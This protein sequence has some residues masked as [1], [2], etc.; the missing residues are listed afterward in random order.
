VAAG[1][2]IITVAFGLLLDVAMDQVVAIETAEP[3]LV[4]KLQAVKDNPV[5]LETILQKKDGPAQITLMW[6]SMLE[7]KAAPD[8]WLQPQAVTAAAAAKAAGYA[9]V[10]A[11]P[12]SPWAGMTISGMSN[13]EPA[14]I[15]AIDRTEGTVAARLRSGGLVAVIVSDAAALTSLRVGGGIWVD[16]SAGKASL[17]GKTACCRITGASALLGR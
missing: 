11:A 16:R 7:E 13:P 15:S 12:P 8:V 2:A 1:A 3:T 17:D 6:S 14:S 9:T 4:G 5:S 10:A